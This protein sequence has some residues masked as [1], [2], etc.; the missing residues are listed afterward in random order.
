MARM[1]PKKA[2]EQYI[3]SVRASDPSA[4]VL[5]VLNHLEE[6]A[7]S[8]DLEKVNETEH[9]VHTPGRHRQKVG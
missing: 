8:G 5:L 9:V 4:D 6:L 1:T 3:E 7:E 2:L